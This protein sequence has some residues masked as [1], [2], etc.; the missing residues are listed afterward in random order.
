MRPF[1]LEALSRDAGVDVSGHWHDIV[2]ACRDKWLSDRDVTVTEG[3]ETL[4]KWI[5]GH[6]P[7]SVTN[8]DMDPLADGDL[9][10][11][12]MAGTVEPSPEIAEMLCRRTGGMV[13]PSMFRR[14]ATLYHDL[15]DLRHL[16]AEIL[17]KKYNAVSAEIAAEGITPGCCHGALGRDAPSGLLF[18]CIRDVRHGGAF[19]VTGLGLAVRLDLSTAIALRDAIDEG[20]GH[21][22]DRIARGAAAA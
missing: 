15:L 21:E 19:I 13:L 10:E 9:I 8:N 20:I 6:G 12:I 14:V 3:G 1:S 5:F 4:A 7:L 16:N 17:R 22:R 18:Q 2:D 11:R